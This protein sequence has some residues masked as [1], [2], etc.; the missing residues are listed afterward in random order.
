MSR[1]SPNESATLFAIGTKKMGNNGEMWIVVVTKTNVKRW[2]PIKNDELSK[3]QHGRKYY[4]HNNGGRPY[5]VYLANKTTVAIFAVDTK[6]LIKVYNN[7]EKV[8]VG[9]YSIKSRRGKIYRAKFTGNSILLKLAGDKYVFIGHC[10]YEFKAVDDIKYYYSLVGNSD[11]PYPVAVGERFVYFMLDSMYINKSDLAA[12]I[13]EYGG[14]VDWENA[15]EY[16]YKLVANKNKL[17]NKAGIEIHKMKN[18]K[19]ISSGL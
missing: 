7:V 17:A 11:V 10:V 3:Y 14:S 1:Q 12:F 18:Y 16:Y 5:V 2:A 4:T 19:L 9:R 15:Y 8:F 13:Q 6:R